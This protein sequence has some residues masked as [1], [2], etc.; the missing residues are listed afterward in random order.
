MAEDPASKGGQMGGQKGGS[1]SA[2]AGHGDVSVS[3][4]NRFIGGVDFPANKKD[5]IE[6]ARGKDAPREV[7]DLMENFPDQEY[8]SAT[9][10]GQAIGDAKK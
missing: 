3:E 5:L 4:V 1:R 10:V 7:L 8:R 6:H 2:E 9:D